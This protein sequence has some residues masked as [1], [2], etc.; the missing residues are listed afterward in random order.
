MEELTRLIRSDMRP[1]LGVTEP[2]A[3]AFAAAKARSYTSGEVISVT[4]KLNSGMYK[5]AFT[6]G[7]PNSREVGSEFAAALGAIAGNEELGLESLSDVK[8]KDAERAEKLVKQGKVQV[9]L[10]DISSRI[11][12]EV[13]VKTK[14]DQAVVTIEDTHTNITGIVVNGEVR[15]ANSKEKTK[16]G[17]AEEKPQ[18]HRYTFRQLCEYADI[19]DVSELEFIWEAYRVNLELFEA[20]MTSER[21]TFAKSLLR[22]NGGMVFSGE[23]QKTASLLCNAAIEA[24]VIG[25]DKPA[26]SITGSG[27]H[28]IIATMPLYAAYK[29]NGYSKE[30]L[31]RATALSY[32][33]CM[34]IKE[35]SGKLSAFCGAVSA[36]CASAAAITYLCGGSVAQIKAT[37]DNTLANIP[38]IICDGAKISCAAKIASSIDAGMMAHYLA[39]NHKAYKAYTGIVKEDTEETISCVGYIGKVGMHQTDKEIIKM[40]LDTQ[41]EQEN[42][43]TGSNPE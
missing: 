8:Q 30:Q 23:E 32:L 34:Y 28:G 20:G 29:V 27:A 38:G 1:A 2:G 35:Y 14:L 18:I 10:Q 41:T 4:V 43:K 9:I 42:G 31:L 26:M 6:C 24:R 5:N 40:M 21:T 16:G 33:I 37:I 22:K 36:S 25:L 17:E 39:M 13:E 15:F 11:F 7:I 12:I 3:I 19:A